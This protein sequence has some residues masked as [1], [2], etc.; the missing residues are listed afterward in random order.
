MKIDSVAVLPNEHDD[1]S[2]VFADRLDLSAAELRTLDGLEGPQYDAW[3]KSRGG[4]AP[5]E[6]DVQIIVHGNAS[7]P[8]TVSDIEA[9]KTCKPPLSGSYF[10]KP[11]AGERNNIEI[12]FDLDQS[13]SAAL[14]SAGR[15]Y[16]ILHSISLAPGETE[17]LLFATR[18]TRSYC[19]YSLQLTAV[20]NGR[21]SV[22]KITDG[23]NPFRVSALP[24]A[25]GK[26]RPDARKFKTIYV[27]GVASPA[28]D[29]SFVRVDPATF[30]LN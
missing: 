9:I 11:G 8:V 22:E 24:E 14:S 2:Y 27:G 28:R 18:T 19:E 1:N 4:V 7:T 20:A 23:G 12:S 3:F 17:T 26:D 25:P 21:K 6:S 30:T 5:D 10:Y 15:N 29:G 13:R 16:F